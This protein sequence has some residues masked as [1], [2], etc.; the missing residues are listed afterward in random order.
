[1]FEIIWKKEKDKFFKKGVVEIVWEFH[2]LFF[3]FF[4]LIKLIHICITFQQKKDVP[5][6]LKNTRKTGEKN[7]GIK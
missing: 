5:R 3:F 7:G 2:I 1:M 4:W 6:K